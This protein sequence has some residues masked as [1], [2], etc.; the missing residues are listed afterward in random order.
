MKIERHPNASIS[1]GARNPAISAP[2]ATQQYINEI[3]KTRL[4]S[5]TYS[6]VSAV[7][8]GKLIPSPMPVTN[9][10]TDS[11]VGFAANAVKIDA[12][13]TA[14]IPP[15]STGRR[16]K[17]SPS[18]ATTAEPANIPIRAADS[19]KENDADSARHSAVSDGTANAIV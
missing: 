11:S 19:A 13:P 6:E 14:I 8:F 17:R 4:R 2:S 3:S 7:A 5:G 16:P 10:Q 1:T 15:I 12:A 9:R 18:G